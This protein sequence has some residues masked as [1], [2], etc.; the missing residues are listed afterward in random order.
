MC[1]TFTQ[2]QQQKT[3]KTQILHTVCIITKLVE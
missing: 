3:Q 2:Q 1:V